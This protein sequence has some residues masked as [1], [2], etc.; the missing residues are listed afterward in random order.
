MAELEGKF[1]ESAVY[2]IFMAYE[3]SYFV[4]LETM[5]TLN[6]R[7]FHSLKF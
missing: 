2:W 3:T 6:Y 5:Q 1:N 4:K 7:N